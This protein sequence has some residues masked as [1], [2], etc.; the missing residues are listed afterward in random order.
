VIAFLKR[1]WWSSIVPVVDKAKLIAYLERIDGELRHP[2][3]LCV[4]GSA[5][6]ILLDEP[7]RTSLDVD[8]AAP[9][10]DADFVDFKRAA[11]AAGLPVNPSDHYAGEHIEW[12]AGLRLCLPPPSPETDITLWQGSLLTLKT[13]AVEQLVASKLIRYDEIDQS[14]IR[15]LL[16]QRGIAYERIAAAAQL[17]PYPFRCD[18]LV[19]ENLQNLRTDMVMW[20]NQEP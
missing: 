15:Y 3:M 13:V 9:Y 17:L 18:P 10:S 12:I 5:A 1:A 8:V 14:D 4:Y 7:D 6:Y 19:L 2:A 16:A 20:G 11:A